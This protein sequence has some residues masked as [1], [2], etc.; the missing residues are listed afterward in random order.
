MAQAFFQHS[1]REGRTAIKNCEPLWF[2]VL[3]CLEMMH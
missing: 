2:Y 3:F 1:G